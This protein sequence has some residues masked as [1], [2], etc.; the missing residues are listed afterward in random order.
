MMVRRS[1]INK[2]ADAVLEADGELAAEAAKHR[3]TAAVRA[4]GWASDL[5]DQPQMR[6]LSALVIGGGLAT[7][8]PRLLRAGLRMLIAHEAATLAKDQIKTRVDR[9]RPRSADTERQSKPKPGTHTGREVSSFPSGHSAGAMAVARA[10]VREFP[11]HRLPAL[12]VAAAVAGAQIPRCAHYGS[13][14]AAGVM[15][16]IAAEVVTNRVWDVADGAIADGNEA[17]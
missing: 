14:V 17:R 12:A 16:G 9:T 10:F 1:T 15:L 4:M 5:G 7:R 8:N 3:D 2:A 6:I 11:E 13:D